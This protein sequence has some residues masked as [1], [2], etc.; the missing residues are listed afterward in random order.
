MSKSFCK[1][2]QNTDRSK[3]VTFGVCTVSA[4]EVK[5]KTHFDMY[6]K[7]NIQTQIDKVQ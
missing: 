1:K 7:W 2:L 5:K 6:C 4:A 3:T